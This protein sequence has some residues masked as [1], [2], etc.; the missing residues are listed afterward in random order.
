MHRVRLGGSCM[1]PEGKHGLSSPS[2]EAKMEMAES[3]GGSERNW[4]AQREYWERKSGTGLSR[5]AKRRKGW[6]CQEEKGTMGI[7]D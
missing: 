3:T 6:N 7:G 4:R 1:G 5:R 2:P